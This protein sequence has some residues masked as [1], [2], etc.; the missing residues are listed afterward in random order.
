MWPPEDPE[1]I[2]RLIQMGALNRL[3]GMDGLPQ[4]DP[5]VAYAHMGQ[6]PGPA[7]DPR[8]GALFGPPPAAAQPAQGQG[9]APPEEQLGE[10]AQLG[11]EAP[12]QQ[13]IKNEEATSLKREDGRDEMRAAA[14]A[15]LGKWMQ[16]A[17]KL[18]QS[19]LKLNQQ[20]ESLIKAVKESGLTPTE[21]RQYVPGA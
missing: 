1:M 11:W 4:F 2:N 7:F 13:A 3:S 16:H 14:I 21:L 20:H 17:A 15:E 19:H 12:P 18:K 6:G 5:A 9:L 10:N 8:L